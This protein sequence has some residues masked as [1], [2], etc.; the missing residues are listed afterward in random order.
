MFDAV[1]MM[2]A[3]VTPTFDIKPS[4]YNITAKRV[5]KASTTLLSLCL[6]CKVIIILKLMNKTDEWQEVV[7]IGIWSKYGQ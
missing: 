7:A 6:R 3:A 1:I 4:V 2:I 5:I